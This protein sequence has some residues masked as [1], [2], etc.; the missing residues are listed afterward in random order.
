M[1]T[2]SEYLRSNDSQN[3]GVE[4]FYG[5]FQQFSTPFYKDRLKIYRYIF[6]EKSSLALEG[7]NNI[8]FSDKPVILKYRYSFNCFHG[9]IS[10]TVVHEL[11][12]F[13][14]GK[15]FLITL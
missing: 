11:F 9:C 14:A 8:D 3:G 1:L 15:T 7:T 12:L 6:A 13:L 4:D 2:I 5:I 10:Y